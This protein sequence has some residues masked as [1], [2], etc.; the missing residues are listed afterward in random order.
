MPT[1]HAA[2]SG[3]VLYS[4]V[5]TG[6]QAE[7]GTS[8][9]SQ[10]DIC[11]TKALSLGLP[12]VAEYED[13]GVSGGFLLSRL[14]MQAALADMTAGRASTLICANLSRYSRDVEHQQA[15]KK[16]VRAVG[17]RLVFCDM[18]FDD[19]PE[20]DL[21]F[22]II[23]GFADYEKAV[24]RA[25][26]MKGKRKRA[27]EGRQPSRKTSPYGYHIVIHADVLRGDFPASELGRYHVVEQRAAVV[28]DI[29]ARYAR[30]SASLS[31]LCRTL[32]TQGLPPPGTGRCWHPSTINGILCNPAYKG[33]AV[34]GKS[35][36]HRDETRLSLPNPR[37][38]ECMTSPIYE[39]AAPLDTWVWIDCPALVPESL[40]EKAQQVM[41][42]HSHLGGSPK[43]VCMLSGRIFCAE[44]GGRM[45][46]ASTPQ[47]A[48]KREGV[49]YCAAQ[50][51]KSRKVREGMMPDPPCS[52]L[53]HKRPAVEQAVVQAIQ[54]ALHSPRVVEAALRAY[55]QAR[56]TGSA[57]GQD[58]KRE[59]TS[60]AR[61]LEALKEEEG[62]TVQAQIAG[63]AAGASLDAYADAFASLAARRK[64][65]LD[66][67][68]TL[69]RMQNAKVSSP[70]R[71]NKQSEATV[72]HVL[73]DVERVLLSPDVSDP[74]KRNLVGTILER[75]A[76]Y[77]PAGLY[78]GG[79][80]IY[81]LPD[82]LSSLLPGWDILIDQ[83]TT[84]ERNVSQPSSAT[85]TTCGM[86]NAR[87]AHIS[88]KCH[89]RA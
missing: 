32:N 70:T 36:H 57:G 25:R 22:G 43:R 10:R 26:T 79:T 88:Q 13:A 87:N 2:K 44:C 83:P 40:W 33:Q 65:L 67:Q 81:F 34:Y 76:C 21:A 62:R 8:L 38:G 48:Y 3:A 45:A 72:S 80:A 77:G 24:I 73:K 85:S 7:V 66:R 39:V 74:D 61:A 50:H 68:G 1:T 5:S 11:R 82:A 84:I 60:L 56:S 37:T 12:I 20:G 15:I 6:E 63:M 27:E 31:D 55:A 17:G 23:G 49:Y 16:A 30:R 28:R 71:Q 54:S 29:F 51:Q 19:T 52:P 9:A 69:K 18:N 42:A 86:V 41:R 75:V 78:P 35:S 53:G 89:T 59:M 64:D 14:G 46:L 58:A 4:R 47:R